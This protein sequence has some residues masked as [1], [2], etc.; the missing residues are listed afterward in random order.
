MSVTIKDVA[1]KAG[2]SVSTV[3]RLIGG[4]GPVSA[5]A[6]V[7]INEAI[8]QL[9]YVPNG[10]A[11]SLI[12]KRTQTLGLLLP[13]LY[14][15]FYSEVL[16]GMDQIAQANGYHLL[17]SSSHNAWNEIEYALQVMQ[18]RVDGLVIMSPDITAA[19]LK[20]TLPK[21][22]PV[23]LLNCFVDSQ[24]FDSINIDNYT[25]ANAIVRHLIRAGHQKIGIITGSSKNFDAQERLR[26][27][28]DAL[29]EHDLPCIEEFIYEGDFAEGSGHKGTTS[30]LQRSNPPTA[31]FCCNDAM[32]IGAMGA[33]RMMGLDIPKDV[34]IV[35][36]DDIPSSQYIAP[37]LTTVHFPIF[38]M[39]ER[40]M[41]RLILAIKEENQHKRRQE[42]LAT[43]L[44]I[45]Q[46]CGAI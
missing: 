43:S 24:D 18:G 23:V 13:D 21:R 2:V 3:S 19:S 27:Y 35:G 7:Q 34:A 46:S 16:R 38:E 9:N 11:R 10:A 37:P 20:Q 1:R 42:I 28:K 14:G 25:G 44:V 30:L 39:G 6:Q 8:Q 5:E 15:G 26:G 31:I 32:A 4:S 12:T 29:K 22:L 17:V 45:R 41:E 36:F 40:A 33:S